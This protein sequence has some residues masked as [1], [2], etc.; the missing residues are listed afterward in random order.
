MKHHQDNKMIKKH[1]NPILLYS[2]CGV[3]VFITLLSGIILSSTITHA[4]T[5]KTS[6]TTVNVALSCNMSIA[7]GTGG[8]ATT[9]GYSYSA[10][11]NPG[12]TQE[13]AGTIITTSC[14]GSGDYSLYAIGYSGDSY[15]TPTNTQL[16]SSNPNVSNIATGTATTGNT[17][18]W[19]FK[20]VSSG[21][22]SPTIIS[23]YNA[24]TSI[25]GSDFTKIANYIP[26]TTGSATTSSVQAKYQVYISS[27][28]P[29]DTYTGKVKYA[30][31]YPNGATPPSTATTFDQA[32]AA[33]GKT[34][35]GNYYKMQDGTDA[36]CAAVT[37][38]QTTTLLDTRG[39][40]TAYTVAKIGDRCWMT[41]NLNLAGGTALSADDTDVTSAY[42][43]SFSTSNNLTK[44]GDTIVLPASTTSSGF[45]TAN[46]SYVANSGNASSSCSSS[47]GCYSYYSW[48]AATLGSGRSI[49]TDNTNAE[50]SICPKGWHLPTTYNG[51]PN[52]STDFRKLMIAL[53]GSESI[54]TYNSS[55]TPTGATMSTA[56]Q[57]SPNNFLLAGY[58]Y[59][60]SFRDGGSAGYYWSS[61]S[62]SGSYNA[63]YLYFRSSSVYSAQ[64]N[65]RRMGY[66]VRCVLGS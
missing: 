51:N 5:T 25:P 18:N 44:T 54:Q 66:S 65:T 49:S 52:S 47:P 4:D 2:T 58:Y 57:A 16:I 28:Q 21:T 13:I 1:Q 48:D 9:D 46:Y 12:T 26:G 17:S 22:Y 35:Q 42:I 3:L 56:L 6:T 23:P 60:G 27:I 11:I 33:A 40:G 50:Q 30:M 19:A 45:D 32:F 10:N 24:Y 20:L 15:D 34:K 31:V 63:R 37:T 53:G 55:T 38:G 41:E 62:Y 59:D 36:I 29:A 64:N 8:T 39:G 43:S 14:N 61:T 7:P